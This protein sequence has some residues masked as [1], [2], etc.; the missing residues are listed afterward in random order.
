MPKS[1]PSYS[2]HTTETS[3]SGFKTPTYA[4]KEPKLG[5]SGSNTFTAAAG[6]GHTASGTRTKFTTKNTNPK[7]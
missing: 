6:Y 3:N 1:N 7:A 5:G 4:G 2:G